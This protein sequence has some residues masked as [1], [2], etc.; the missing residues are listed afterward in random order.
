MKDLEPGQT[1]CLLGYPPQARLLILNADDFGMCYAINA[2]IIHA[3]KVGLVRSTSLMVPC[4]WSMH[5]IRYLKEHPDIPFGVHLTTIC[6]A[7][8]Y[9][10]RPM[11]SREKVPSLVDEMGYFYHA[12]RMTEFL[13]QVRIE[14]L[15][16]EFRAQIEFV[17][18]AGLKPSHLDWHY[19]ANGARGELFELI[20][21]LAIAYGLALRVTGQPQIEKVQ[22]W[23]LPANDH[24]L[25]DSFRIEPDHKVA[26]F[27]RLLHALPAGLSEWAVHPGFDNPE[28]LAIEPDGQHFRQADHDFWVS[29][30]ARNLIEE[31]Q[32]ILID[33]RSL[34]DVWGRGAG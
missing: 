22:G 2:A 3:L 26:Q 31:E 15:E 9:P 13:A 30:E 33:Y 18:S 14:E 12:E 6:D 27:T 21:R 28:L 16:G 5:A 1:N 19:L 23:G 7:A 10:W 32:I 8:H 4:P 34:Q 29:D 24:D 11:L 20:F 17:L 25:L